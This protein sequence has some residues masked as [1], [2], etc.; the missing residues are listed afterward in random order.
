MKL[1][2]NISKFIKDPSFFNIVKGMSYTTLSKV[3]AIIFGF[4]VNFIIS[5]YYG[6]DVVGLVAAIN[7]I[8]LIATLF[9]VFG[10]HEMI[11]KLTSQLFATQKI[12]AIINV[13]KKTIWFVMAL[14]IVIASIIYL[15]S[16][17]IVS[18]LFQNAELNDIIIW[19][20]LFIVVKSYLL[21]NLGVIRGLRSIKFFA[22]LQVL[23]SFLMT[24]LIVV[25][26][27]FIDNLHLPIYIY[28]IVDLLVT[29]IGFIYIFKKLNSFENKDD[30]TEEIS[31][32]H[33][34]LLSGP[35][36]ITAS[37]FVLTSQID[38]LIL[39]KYQSL[40]EVGVYSIAVKLSLLSIFTI[41]AINSMVA[42]KF[43]E[44]HH[45]NKHTELIYI[46]KK[47]SIL[48]FW[49]TIPIS[50]FLIVFGKYILGIFGETF[51][52]GY[53]ALII[54]TIAHTVNALAGSNGMLL[55]MTGYQKEFMYIMFISIILNIVLN[56]ILIPIY[57][58]NGAAI[59]TL[60]SVVTWNI[61]AT[62]LIKVKFGYFIID[63]P[64]KLK[65]F[66]KLKL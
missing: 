42:P 40:S 54:L 37:I 3:M 38:I 27:Q 64:L 59:A 47:S 11:L 66:L 31:L 12:K 24:I 50:L 15:N 43:S 29:I 48:I 49:T 1:P 6:A 21:V 32:K 4:I 13:Y 58:I 26:M 5:R 45:L 2:E 10:M 52:L 46:A 35:M 30:E 55:N 41:S 28:F 17:F 19:A 61:L 25:L 56:I 34:L 63:N 23:P 60:I 36:F 22:V 14:S 18:Y 65:N 62:V 57:S 53:E 9:A 7:S 39:T 20:A 16:E 8:L 44:L 51:Y 33:M